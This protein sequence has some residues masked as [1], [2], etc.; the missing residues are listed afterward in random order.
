MQHYNPKNA[1]HQQQ[2]DAEDNESEHGGFF[3]LFFG[4]RIPQRSEPTWRP[5]REIFPCLRPKG[6]AI[7]PYP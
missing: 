3:H 4:K 1:Y 7:L 5:D 6:V 2:C